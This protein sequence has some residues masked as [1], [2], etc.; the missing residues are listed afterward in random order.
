M[1]KVPA[2]VQFSIRQ[3]HNGST[4]SYTVGLPAESDLGWV[5][6]PEPRRKLASCRVVDTVDSSAVACC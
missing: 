2:F 1:S 3:R 4:E 5:W 6:K